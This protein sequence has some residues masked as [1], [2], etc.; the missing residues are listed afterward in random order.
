[1]QGVHL[2]PLFQ[3]R[4][5]DIRIFHKHHGTFAKI[6]CGDH[7]D[8]VAMKLTLLKKISMQNAED[9]LVI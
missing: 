2:Q 6:D 4:Y 5:S 8:A 7:L 9:K 1:M 3:I